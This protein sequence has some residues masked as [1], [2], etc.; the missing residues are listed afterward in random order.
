MPQ[1]GCAAS[2]LLSRVRQFTECR[3]GLG[4]R[5]SALVQFC[6]PR[7]QTAVQD[8][9]RAARWRPAFNISSQVSA[10]NCALTL[11]ATLPG[12]RPALSAAKVVWTSD[13]ARD[14]P[15]S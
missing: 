14:V 1:G 8:I 10:H 4:V 13:Y 12:S 5:P 11:S 2:D 3:R 6:L 9:A 15:T 7:L